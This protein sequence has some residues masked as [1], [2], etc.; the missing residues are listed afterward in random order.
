[1]FDHHERLLFIPITQILKK[2]PRSTQLQK[3]KYTKAFLITLSISLPVCY[4][5]IR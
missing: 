4:F 1:L 2:K 5:T 3:C